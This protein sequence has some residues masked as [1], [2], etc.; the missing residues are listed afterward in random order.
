[1]RDEW[2]E[3]L[4]MEQVII[5]L[6]PHLSHVPHQC[7]RVAVKVP[8][9]LSLWVGVRTCQSERPEASTDAL[10][11]TTR[12]FLRHFV[13]SSLLP[14]YLTV[15]ADNPRILEHLPTRRIC[16]LVIYWTFEAIF[17]ASE[18][19]TAQFSE[20]EDVIVISLPRRHPSTVSG[21]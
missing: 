11:R 8:S 9:L 15:S 6:S 10:L 13:P 4:E 21:K 20:L 19:W 2:D 14:L 17:D 1:M 16:L 18:Q 12:C 3:K 5:Y 7:R